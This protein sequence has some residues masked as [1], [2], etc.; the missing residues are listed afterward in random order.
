MGVAVTH[1][2]YVTTVK[3]R[4][5]GG[6]VRAQVRLFETVG[7]AEVEKRN[8]AEVGVGI[9]EAV[10]EKNGGALDVQGVGTQDHQGARIGR[11]TSL[12][13]FRITMLLCKSS[14]V[15]HTRYC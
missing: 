9:G 3:R 11:F 7:G 8:E 6:T 4:A 10:K 14:L 15:D 13:T 1:R 2:H 12:C 5:V